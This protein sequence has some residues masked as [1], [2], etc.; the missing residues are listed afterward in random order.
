MQIVHIAQHVLACS[1]ESSTTQSTMEKIEAD[2]FI[3]INLSIWC[4]TFDPGKH[5]FY[6]APIFSFRN[7]SI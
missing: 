5:N 6:R 2:D 3:D 4:V 7:P 1:S